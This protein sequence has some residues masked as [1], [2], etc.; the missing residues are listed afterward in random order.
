MRSVVVTGVSTGIGWGIM[1][2]LIQ[3]G[4]R[5]FGS[6]RKAQDAERLDLGTANA[7]VD[8]NSQMETVE[9]VHRPKERIR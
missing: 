7:A 2:V 6:V 4:F 8:A 3:N 5:V 1:K 9:A